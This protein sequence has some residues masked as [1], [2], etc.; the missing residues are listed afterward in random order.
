MGPS[1]T[2]MKQRYSQTCAKRYYKPAKMENCN[3]SKCISQSSVR[4]LF[5]DLLVLV[6]LLLLTKRQDTKIIARANTNSQL[7]EVL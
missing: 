2:D 4:F 5:V 6:L 1:L 7:A 3:L